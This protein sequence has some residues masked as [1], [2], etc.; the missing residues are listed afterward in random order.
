MS[1]LAEGFNAATTMEWRKQTGFL[2]SVP[3]SPPEKINHT[4][5]SVTRHR[6]IAQLRTVSPSQRAH[7]DHETV[8][9]AEPVSAPNETELLR[10]I[11]PLYDQRR[12]E[13]AQKNDRKTENQGAPCDHSEEENHDARSSSFQSAIRARNKLVSMNMYIVHHA[14]ARVA[15]MAK[16]E[17]ADLVQ[18]GAIALIRAAERFD[19]AQFSHVKFATYGYRAVWTAVW[20]AVA[21]ASDI[22][23]IPSRLRESLVRDNK[24]VHMSQAQADHLRS[25]LYPARLDKP[26]KRD[27]P[28]TLGD[29][30]PTERPS[31]SS[32][33]SRE[34]SRK[35]I[36]D[37]CYRSLPKRW[38]SVLASRF[39][40]EQDLPKS[41]KEVATEFG[42]SNPRVTQI[43]LAALE[44]LKKKEPDL[45]DLLCDV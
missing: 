25:L 35:E 7:I 41:I 37:A 26:L 29:L 31:P 4:C 1:Q 36:R 22:V 43:V 19:I 18:E 30:V 10:Q 5:T 12:A 14:A 11:R 20:R 27:E 2:T 39:G 9:L 17:K 3:L 34:F 32:V 8:P 38:A 45:V 23:R 33:L 28:T 15:K 24:K 44:R 21:P 40:L 13:Q 16:C 6:P 42:I